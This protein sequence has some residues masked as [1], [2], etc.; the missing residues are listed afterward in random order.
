MRFLFVG[1]HLCAQ[2]SSGQTL[3][4]L[5]LPSTSS[6]IRPLRGH[7]RYSYRGLSPHQFMPMPGVHKKMQRNHKAYGFAAR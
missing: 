4:G 3:A 5:P 7:L 2:A 1:S 6:Y